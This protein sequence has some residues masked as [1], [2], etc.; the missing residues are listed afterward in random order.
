MPATVWVIATWLRRLYRLAPGRTVY[1]LLEAR[2]G[3]A[4]QADC[5]MIAGGNVQVLPMRQ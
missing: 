4:R 2:D 3:Q 5:Y 1:H